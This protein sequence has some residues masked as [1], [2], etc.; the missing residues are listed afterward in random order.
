MTLAINSPVE[1]RVRACFRT[2]HALR[3]KLQQTTPPGVE[4]A[5]L[6]MGMSDDFEWAIE[7]GATVVRV[8]QAIFGTRALPNS[9]YWPPEGT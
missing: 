7:E 3:D 5:E 6:S 4:L 8:G 2:L 9:Y 1:A